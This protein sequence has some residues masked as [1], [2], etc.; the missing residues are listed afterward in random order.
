M[1][2]KSNNGFRFYDP[3]NVFCTLLK[4]KTV[5]GKKSDITVGHEPYALE[6]ADPCIIHT[7]PCEVIAFCDGLP[8]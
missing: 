4:K 6:C 5:A 7:L 1:F 2:D 3:K 8:L